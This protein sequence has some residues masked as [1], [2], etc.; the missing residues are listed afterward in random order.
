[1]VNDLDARARQYQALAQAFGLQSHLQAIRQT[2]SDYR[3]A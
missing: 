3:I 2:T 1:M